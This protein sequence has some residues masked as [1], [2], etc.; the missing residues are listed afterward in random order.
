MLM[1]FD[2]KWKHF[3]LKNNFIYPD[4]ISNINF[5]LPIHQSIKVM[6]LFKVDHD[7]DSLLFQLESQ[8]K[9]YFSYMAVN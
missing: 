8:H 6:L 1:V 7:Q 5:F 9:L 4:P 3:E 2:L